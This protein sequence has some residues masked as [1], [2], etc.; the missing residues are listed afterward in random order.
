MSNVALVQLVGEQTIQNLLQILRLGPDRVVHL[1][2]PKTAGKT[3]HIRAA[4]KSQGFNHRFLAILN[5]PRGR[6]LA[7]LEQR[8]GALGI[9]ILTGEDIYSDKAFAGGHNR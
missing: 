6:T 9:R 1:V 8:A 4:A 3:A 2:T 5:P 7:N